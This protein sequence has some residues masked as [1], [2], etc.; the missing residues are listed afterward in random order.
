[1]NTDDVN[2]QLNI[3][4]NALTAIDNCALLITTRAKRKPNKYMND[5]TKNK[6][7]KDK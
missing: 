6:L 7:K 3:F 5:T 4:N 2:D 1:M